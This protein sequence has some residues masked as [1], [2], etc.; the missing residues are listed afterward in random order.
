MDKK[1]T[2]AVIDIGSNALHM[3]IAQLKNGKILILEELKHPLSLGR[4]TFSLGKISLEKIEKCC[5]IIN[6]F[7]KAAEGYGIKYVRIIATA[8]LRE[9]EN[10]EYVVEQIRIR[11]GISVKILDDSGEKNLIYKEILKRLEK[12]K[13]SKNTA[14]LVYIGV[15]SLGVSVYDKGVIPFAQNIRMGSLKLSEMLFNMQEYEAQY[16]VI[17]EDYM[18]SFS[19]TFY[20]TLPTGK[21]KHF[22][23]CGREISI[24]SE[25]C[26]AEKSGEVTIIQKDKFTKLYNSIKNKTPD[27]I[28]EEYGISAEAAELIRPAISIYNMFFGSVETSKIIAPNVDIN[29]GIITE[30]LLQNESDEYNKGF[31]KNTVISA[32]AIAKRYDYDEEHVIYVEKYALKIFDKIKKIHGLGSKERL[33]LQVAAIMHDI[34]KYINI[35]SHYIYSY[36]IIRGSEVVGLDMKDMELVANIAMYHSTIIPSIQDSNY[37]RL[38]RKERMVVSKLSAILRIAEALDKGHIKKFDDIDLKVK[39]NTLIVGISTL[40]N[41]QVEEWSFSSKSQ[42]FQ[43]VFGMSTVIKKKRVV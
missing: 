20:N 22:I 18:R 13:I 42:F 27:Q 29:D 15:G 3:K 9:A 1:S 6:K 40:K 24:I 7:L 28:V 2:A 34:G 38:M 14:L 8:A 41:T 39:D 23:A 35:K 16:N 11:T 21:I 17:I 19:K 26:D 30:M 37:S 4:D 5:D 10:R 31:W 25:L 32:R 43:E 12:S 33:L 36:E